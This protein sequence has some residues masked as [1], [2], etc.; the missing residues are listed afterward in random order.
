MK[1]YNSQ[2]RVS[3]LVQLTQEIVQAIDYFIVAPNQPERM[4]IPQPHRGDV[5]LW[6]GWVEDYLS[7][8]ATIL[9]KVELEDNAID[10]EALLAQAKREL[11]EQL[12][13]ELLQK[14][15]AQTREEL[16]Q[17]MQQLT[18][19][20]FTY[21]RDTLKQELSTQLA[22]DIETRSTQISDRLARDIEQT[23]GRMEKSLYD[24]LFS[25]VYIGVYNVLHEE[26]E[27]HFIPLI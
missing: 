16:Q 27:D 20:L 5:Q 2:H 8:A 6:L 12:H 26:N 22:D 13:P 17:Q 18:D 23:A 15:V 25:D 21:V 24:K 19:S 9:D 7:A 4:Q 10:Y 14:L 11:Y 1:G 3:Q